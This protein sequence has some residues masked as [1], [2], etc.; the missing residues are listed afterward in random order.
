[1]MPTRTP[2][3]WTAPRQAGL[4]LL[5]L[6]PAPGGPEAA[7]PD[8]LGAS[9]YLRWTLGGRAA[10]RPPRVD[11]TVERDLQGLVRRLVR[12]RLVV[13]AHDAVEG[14][15]GIALAEMCVAGREPLGMKVSLPGAGGGRRVDVRLFGEQPSRVIVAAEVDCK[16]A[17]FRAAA[18]ARVAVTAL[19][20]TGGD[21]L[22]IAG[23]ARIGLAELAGAW[24]NGFERA[25]FGGS[26][27][28]GRPATLG[29]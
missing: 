16:D 27:R 2:R 20:T 24:R 21:F 26:E 7:T 25:V 15:L 14:G 9:E 29:G 13:A 19:G 28:A 4:E 23:V 12:E 18:T 5:L 6:G 3:V 11:W 8:A 10:G 22:E 17:I 1:M